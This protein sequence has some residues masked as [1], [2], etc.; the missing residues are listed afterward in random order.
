MRNYTSIGNLNEYIVITQMSLSC[1]PDV[2]AATRWNTELTV[3][4][5]TIKFWGFQPPN[6]LQICPC[7]RQPNHLRFTMYAIELCW[8]FYTDAYLAIFYLNFSFLVVMSI[9]IQIQFLL[10]SV[11]PFNW[12]L[13]HINIINIVMP[14]RSVFKLPANLPLPS[15]A[16]WDLQYIQ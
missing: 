15:P 8:I 12:L 5:Y 7:Q 10:C 11:F 6:F 2:V 3:Q 9:L 1:K 16:I 14:G 4:L 13:S